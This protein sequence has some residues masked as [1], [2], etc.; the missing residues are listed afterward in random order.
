[1]KPAWKDSSQYIR[2]VFLIFFISNCIGLFLYFVFDI[3]ISD[4]AHEEQRDYYDGVD[5][6]TYFCTAVPV[7]AVCFLVNVAWGIKALRDIFRR[8]DYHA[9]VAGGVVAALWAANFGVCFFLAR[10]AI[11]NGT[12]HFPQ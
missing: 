2:P 11:Q 7:L 4:S 12:V 6:I 8:K 1:M 9:F 3:N 5:G 10:V